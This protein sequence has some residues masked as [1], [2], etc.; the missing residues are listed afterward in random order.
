[1]S[2]AIKESLH[3]MRSQ[4][5]ERIHRALEDIAAGKMVVLVDDEQR[6]NEGDLVMAADMVT[7]E[8]I[9]FMARYGRGLICLTLEPGKVGELGLPMMVDKNQTKSGTAFTVSIE[10]RHGVTTG[11]SAADRAHTVKVAVAKGTRADDIVSPGHIFP[12]RAV[13]GGVLQ[14]AG[15]TEGSVDLA[16][17]AGRTPAG[18]ICEIMNDDGSMARMGDLERFAEQHGLRILSIADLIQYRLQ[19]ERLVRKVAEGE[20]VL[21]PG[22]RTWKAHVYETDGERGHHE[23]LALTL[24][25]IDGSP[26]LVRVQVGSVIGDVFGA[27]FGTRLIAR[28]AMTRIEQ[29]G[30]G[31][32]LFIPP[33]A[34]LESDLAYHLGRASERPAPEVV[35]REIGFGSQV[36]MDLGVRRM[37]LLTNTPSRI[38]A[39]D[40]FE[41]EVVEQVLLRAPEGT[42]G[43][44]TPR[45]TH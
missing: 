1:M 10:A 39:V 28:D 30:K 20:L 41:L 44:P 18:V 27:R 40:G 3:P 15:H 25:A 8:A 17:L 31:V 7:P 9:N 26:T 29:E 4:A 14:R 24:G 22:D 21:T 16:R 38:V 12:L 43:D 36:L 34:G 32:L 11:I 23:M 33:R 5:I 13:E 35:I 19:T 6:E 45:I 42:E 37:R 2:Y